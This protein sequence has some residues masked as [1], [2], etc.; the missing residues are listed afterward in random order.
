MGS[1][2]VNGL[3]AA[4]TATAAMASLALLQKKRAAAYDPKNRKGIAQRRPSANG[5][6]MNGSA[7]GHTHLAMV[8]NGRVLA[9][10]AEGYELFPI[11]FSMHV[12]IRQNVVHRFLQTHPEAKSSAAA[13]LVHGGV[14][15]DRYDTDIQYNFHQESFFQYLF[16]VREPGCAGLVDLAS[17]KAVLFVPRLSDEWELWC[18]DRKPLAY[19]KAHYKVDEVFYMDEMAAVLADKLKAKKLY[20]LHGKNTDSGLETTTTS[21]FEGIEKFEVDKAALHPVLVECRV[22]KTE[23]ELELLRFVNKLSSRAHINVMKNIRPGKMEFHAESD[24]LHY[25]YS[26]GGARFHAY[27]CICGSGHNASALHY[28]HAG[29]PNDKLLE[30]GDLFLNDMGGELHGYTSDITCSWPVNGVFS[31]DQRMVYEGVLKAHDA[32]MAAIK[33]GVSYVD[34]HL[35]SHRVLTQHLLEYG[36]FQNGTVDELMD[37]EISAYFYPHGLG[38]MMGLDTH[39]VGGIPV[40]YERSTKKILAKLRCVRNLENNMVLTVEPGCYFIEAQIQAVLANPVTAKFVNQEMLSRFRGTGG[41]RI[42]SDVV[43]T[44]RGVE[45]MSKVP[46]T[47]EQIEAT[48]QKA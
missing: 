44:A 25:V 10:P 13:I 31:A 46:R 38:H 19:F 18:G 17:R 5:A 22:I 1:E 32:V 9:D 37:H 41:V 36:L 4:A 30:D 28:G 14:E 29:A 12:Q 23:K 45:C 8:Q 3:L 15:V 27:T 33:P 16:G 48:M 20:V 24:F 34:M 42:E 40:G 35:L 43:V 39:D 47:V 6:A 2:H 26:N 7:N 11:D 21:T